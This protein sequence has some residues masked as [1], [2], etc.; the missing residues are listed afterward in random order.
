[1]KGA[2]KL[3]EQKVILI[4]DEPDVSDI[5]PIVIRKQPQKVKGD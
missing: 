2:N 1:M 4:D 3:S 5:A